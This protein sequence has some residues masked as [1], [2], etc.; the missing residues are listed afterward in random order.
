MTP[1][2]LEQSLKFI[3]SSFF[4]I[5]EFE[6]NALLVLGLMMKVIS[7]LVT[8]ISSLNSRLEEIETRLSTSTPGSQKQSEKQATMLVQGVKQIYPR[9]Y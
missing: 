5:G 4:E 1:E 8:E 7:A 9:L 6:P 2:E 3:R